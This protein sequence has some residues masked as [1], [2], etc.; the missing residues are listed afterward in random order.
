MHERADDQPLLWTGTSQRAPGLFSPNATLTPL[1]PWRPPAA[2]EP[3]FAP[4]AVARLTQHDLVVV[5]AFFARALD[6][7]LETRAAMAYRILGEMSAKMTVAPPEGNPERALESL[8]VQMRG[9][10]RRF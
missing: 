4:D 5:E 7:P 6:L 10:G 8:A 2:A 9:Q 3:L 1:E